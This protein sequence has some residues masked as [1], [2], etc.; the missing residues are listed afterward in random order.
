MV[1]YNS[2][3]AFA[4]E[5]KVIDSLSKVLDLVDDPIIGMTVYGVLSSFTPLSLRLN[6]QVYRDTGGWPSAIPIRP[7]V[8]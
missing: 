3:S 8:E 5:V 4:N 6:L 2:F 7:D 1:D